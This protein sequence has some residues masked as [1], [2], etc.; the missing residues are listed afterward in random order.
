MSAPCKLV[1]MLQFSLIMTHSNHDY[2][3]PFLAGVLSD[4][5]FV[6][7]TNDIGDYVRLGLI[8]GVGMAFIKRTET[9]CMRDCWR[10]TFEVLAHW[11][12]SSPH[13]S[14]HDAMVDELIAAFTTLDM[15]DLAGMVRAGKCVCEDKMWD[16]FE[17][18]N[19]SVIRPGNM[20]IAVNNNRLVATVI[21]PVT[22]YISVC[23]IIG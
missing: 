11:R 15:N 17:C 12:E 6:R 23:I 13:Q 19:K 3:F 9:N 18:I 1:C 16:C 4:N 7:L 10:T 5:F 22:T 2:P 20:D 21:L 8:L 14:D